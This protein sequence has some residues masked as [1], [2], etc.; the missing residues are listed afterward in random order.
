MD[1]QTR[2]GQWSGRQTDQGR[3]KRDVRRR[4]RGRVRDVYVV[5]SVCPSCS[6]EGIP[7]MDCRLPQ[8]HIDLHTSNTKI[9][10]ILH[11]LS[12]IWTLVTVGSLFQTDLQRSDSLQTSGNFVPLL[13]PPPPKRLRRPSSKYFVATKYCPSVMP[14]TFSHPKL[15]VLMQPTVR[16][17]ESIVQKADGKWTDYSCSVLALALIRFPFCAPTRNPQE[18]E[19]VGSGGIRKKKLNSPPKNSLSFGVQSWLHLIKAATSQLSGSGLA[20]QTLIV[21]RDTSVSVNILNP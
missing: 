4:S 11:A 13:R 20:C 12:R 2:Q 3:R 18:T 19:R 21:Y 14:F 1:Y 5:H 16:S 9:G 15:E 6:L 10:L 8:A 7:S 17:S